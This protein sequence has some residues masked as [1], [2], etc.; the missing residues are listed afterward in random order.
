MDTSAFGISGTGTEV[1][2]EMMDAREML[3][4]YMDVVA[5]RWPEAYDECALVLS[6]SGRLTDFTLYSIGYYDP[7]VMD[8][9]TQDTLNGK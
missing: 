2:N 4:E 7:E 3:E 6:S 5:G 8:K 9:M 1:F